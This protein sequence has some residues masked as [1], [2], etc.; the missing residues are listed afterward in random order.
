MPIEFNRDLLIIV[1]QMGLTSTGIGII[2]LCAITPSYIYWKELK[3]HPGSLILGICIAEIAMYYGY[4]WMMLRILDILEHPLGF[5]MYV[6]IYHLFNYLS[7][8]SLHF[9][10]GTIF[11]LTTTIASSALEISMFY[12]AFISI[13]IV[14]LLHNPFYSPEWR[15]ILY[16]IFALLLPLSIFLPFRV[17]AIGIYI[18][19]YTNFK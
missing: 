17:T 18:Y 13:D 8:N 15:T 10:Q 1:L 12:Y 19:I 9:T 4:F 2:C 14:F 7:G 16:H 6:Y 3:A 11:T 5:N